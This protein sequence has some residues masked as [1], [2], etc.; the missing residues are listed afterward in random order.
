MRTLTPAIFFLLCSAVPLFAVQSPAS[1]DTCAPMGTS[2]M[3]TTLYFGLARP[4]GMVSEGQWKS[5]LR[6]HVTPRFPQGLTVWEARGQWQ[7]PDGRITRERS[8]VLMLMHD[9]SEQVRSALQALVE[10]YKKAFQQESV[11]WESARVC[12]A[13]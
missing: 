7:R 4:T 8:K 12:A 13:F 1:I 2:Y 5:F 6:E 11:L 10:A 3:R 9:Q